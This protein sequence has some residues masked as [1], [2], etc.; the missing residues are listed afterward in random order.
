MS[1]H[2]EQPAPVEEGPNHVLRAFTYKG[3]SYRVHVLGQWILADRWWDRTRRSN[4]YYSR[5]VTRD[6]Q[7]FE[8]YLDV[9]QD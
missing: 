2:I 5:V 6:H 7:V 1:R 4:R 3:I 8:L 9:A